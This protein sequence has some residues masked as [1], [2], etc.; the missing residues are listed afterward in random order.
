MAVESKEA[1]ARILEKGLPA[2]FAHLTLDATEIN[3]KTLRLARVRF[4]AFSCLLWRMFFD[5]L[6]WDRVDIFLYT[7]GSPQWRGVELLASSFHLKYTD[8]DG[9]V[10]WWHRLLPCVSIGIAMFSA[11]GKAITLLWQIFLMAGP[12][13]ERMRRFL[14][15]VT[16]LTLDW[17]TE[18]KL[19]DMRDILPAFCKFIAVPLPRSWQTHDFLFPRALM[20]PGM[21]HSVDRLIRRSLTSLSFFPSFLEGLKAVNCFVREH[22]SDLKIALVKCGHGAVADLIAMIKLPPFAKWRWGT[23]TSRL[24]AAP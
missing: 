13:Y 14:L 9:T 10:T 19:P 24:V 4:D 23:F 11:L 1:W 15:R 3:Y 17:G 12:D 8:E 6:D 20:Q 21:R 5:S 7:D 16:S 22:K 2:E 18:S